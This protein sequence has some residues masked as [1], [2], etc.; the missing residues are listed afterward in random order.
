[1]GDWT[2][3][4]P[5]ILSNY[6]PWGNDYHALTVSPLVLDCS[7]HLDLSSEFF[8]IKGCF[9]AESSRYFGVTKEQEGA[10]FIEEMMSG[11]KVVKAFV[12][13]EKAW[14]LIGSMTNI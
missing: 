5:T 8:I 10:A 6:H 11:Q 12:H 3:I 2:V 9:L 13:E 1:M 4:P 14:V 7:L